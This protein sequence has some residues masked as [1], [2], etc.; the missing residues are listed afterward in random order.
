MSD[1]NTDYGP[2]LD[3]AVVMPKLLADHDD[4]L[5]VAGLAGSARDV[6]SL[7]KTKPN[8]FTMA[9]AMGGACAMGLGL[10]LAQPTKRVVVVTGDGELLMNVGS[11]AMIAVMA[12]P[13]LSVICV[14]NGRYQET[15]NQVSHTGLGVDLETIAR[16][17]GFKATR[18]VAEE[19]D[20]EEA[21]RLVMGSNT[22]SFVL[23]KINQA[24]PPRF[25]RSLE[26]GPV[27]TRFREALL[28]HE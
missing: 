10:A 14:D 15:G 26:P 27:V 20:V 18:T 23:V 8:Y 7:C 22:P 1:T 28:G 4:M 21:R 6:A 11:L 5:I 9:G 24:P 3:R 2:G 17:S 12:P 25:K 13:N 19:K 16:G